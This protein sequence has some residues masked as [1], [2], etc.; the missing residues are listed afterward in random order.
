MQAG[1]AK[2][3]ALTACLRTLTTIL[4]AMASRDG[5]GLCRGTEDPDVMATVVPMPSLREEFSLGN[6]K[7]SALAI[8]SAASCDPIFDSF[9]TNAVSIPRVHSVRTDWAPAVL[10]GLSPQQGDAAAA[11]AEHFSPLGHA[12]V[13]KIG[14]CPPTR[15]IA[16][17]SLC[18]W[19]LHTT[20]RERNP[21]CPV[22]L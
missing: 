1:K 9:N 3:L 4:N 6:L 5:T 8:D 22:H 18:R 20:A 7:V 16:S 17:R 15:M 14:E 2:K 12:L 11:H 21:L 10:R 13:D 19:S